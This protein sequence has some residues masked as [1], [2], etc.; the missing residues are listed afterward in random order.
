LAW[1]AV[2]PACA[3]AVVVVVALVSSDSPSSLEDVLAVVGV[4]TVEDDFEELVADDFVVVAAAMHP[5]RTSMPPTLVTPAM[6]RARRAGCGFGRFVM[7]PS[8]HGDT[9]SICDAGK[10]RLGASEEP[11][12][13]RV[14]TPQSASS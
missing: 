11:G 9:T 14:F 4:V 10:R 1:E 7:T 12:K 5:V 8:F 3:G 2:L 6:R 13:N